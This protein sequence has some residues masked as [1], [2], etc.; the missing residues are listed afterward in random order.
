MEALWF[1]EEDTQRVKIFFL[2]KVLITKSFL[3]YPK[4]TFLPKC[5]FIVLVYALHTTATAVHPKNMTLCCTWSLKYFWSSDILLIAA[6][7]S[8]LT[9]NIFLWCQRFRILIW[10]LFTTKSNIQNH[11]GQNVSPSH[12]ID[13]IHTYSLNLLMSK[14]DLKVIQYAVGRLCFLGAAWQ[15]ML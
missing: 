6:L 2:Q 15:K 8:S 9:D 4:W 5:L 13:Y 3:S 7:S 11:E 14:S 12:F 1:P 10:Y